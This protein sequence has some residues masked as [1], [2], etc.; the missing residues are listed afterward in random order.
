MYTMKTIIASLDK[1]ADTLQ[2]I[3]G[4]VH[5]AGTLDA[6][7][8]SLLTAKPEEETEQYAEKYSLLQDWIR[9][10]NNSVLQNNFTSK[11][12]RKTQT[13][14]PIPAG[15]FKESPEWRGFVSWIGNKERLEGQ[16]IPG[17]Y[18]HGGRARKQYFWKDLLEIPTVLDIKFEAA[19]PGVERSLDMGAQRYREHQDALAP[20]DKFSPARRKLEDLFAARSAAI[21]LDTKLQVVDDILKELAQSKYSS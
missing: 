13:D 11:L 20:S 7:A 18:F 19:K 1:L 2:G 6:V 9:T 3:P 5:L 15:E 12:N 16:E 21:K 14:R 4:L 8:N 10:L 17:R